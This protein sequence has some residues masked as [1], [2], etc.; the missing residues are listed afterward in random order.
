MKKTVLLI[1][2]ALAIISKVSAQASHE[3]TLKLFEVM[4]L[5][6]TLNAMSD[7]MTGMFSKLPGMP[8]DDKVT[9]EYMDYVSSE[10]R[11]FSSRMITAMVP[12]YEG[13]FT[14]AEIQKYIDF[15]STPE[16]KK[17]IESAPILQK[18]LMNTVMAKEMPAMQEKFRK[19]IE[20]LNKKH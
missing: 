7:N 13:Y 12:I 1:F 5:D 18:Q 16:G 14:Q 17:L 20:E 10:V 11:L 9:K 8:K 15:Y 6:K 3:K 4:E 2:L 19:K